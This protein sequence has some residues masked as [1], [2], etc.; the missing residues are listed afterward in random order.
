MSI[1]ALDKLSYHYGKY[2]NQVLKNITASFDEG[3]LV[4]IMGRSGAGK[5]TLLSLVSGLD[6]A[7]GGRVLYRDQ[8]VSKLDRD[9]YRAKSV[10]L[11][12]QGYNLL[13]NASALENVVLSMQISGV[14]SKDKKGD[15]L[16]LLAKLGIDEPT[17][18]R[19][20]LK[21]SGGEQQ[22]VGIARALAHDP[23]VIIAD[24][25]TGNLDEESE[26]I[27]M[28]ILAKLAHDEGKCVLVVTHSQSVANYADKTWRLREGKLEQ[29]GPVKVSVSRS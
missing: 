26:R 29:K 15:A 14:K 24:E 3:S 1:L 9:D 7:T 22:R 19:K 6:T 23:D 11:I 4:S 5:T 16:A 27:I 8:D 17:A 25:P 20:V 2:N 13:T 28:D 10:G 12:F 18:K 21:M